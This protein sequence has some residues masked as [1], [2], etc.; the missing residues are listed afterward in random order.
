MSKV[1]EE[2][3]KEAKKVNKPTNE[4][5]IKSLQSQYE[6]HVKQ[7]DYHKEMSLKALG[8]IEI[9]TQLEETNES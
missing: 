4:E 9:L 5:V 3:K 2:Y 6:Q 1:K 7:S 8:A